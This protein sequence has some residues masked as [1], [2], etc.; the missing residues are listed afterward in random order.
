M[1]LLGR[2]AALI[3]G[4]LLVGLCE[5]GLWL[6]DIGPNDDLFIAEGDSYR[7]NPQAARRFFPHQYARLAPGQDRF[8]R[9][10]GA[11]TFRVFALGAS[12]LLGFPNPPQTSFP[13]FLQLMLE[14][15][16]PG[17]RIEVVNCG[18]T[19]INSFVLLDFIEEVVE[20][21][22][23]LVLIY[24]GHNEFV[25]P[26]GAATPFVRLGSSGSFIR[27]QMV[28]QRSKIYYLL[29]EVV[30]HAGEL[31]QGE[32]KNSSFG[33]HLVQREVYP[34]DEAHRLTE[35]NYRRNLLEILEVVR[36]NEV[37][38]ALCTLASNLEG[39][40]P[41]RSQGAAPPVDGTAPQ[42]QLQTY[43]HHAAVHFEAGLAYRAAGDSVRALAT[44]TQA[45]DHDGIHLRAC[46]PFNEII[47]SLAP[48]VWLV[49][50]ERDFATHASHGL[51]GDE[52]ITEY[53]H[54]TVWGHYLIARSAFKEIAARAGALGLAGGDPD[55]LDTFAD[56]SRRLGYG[57]RERILARNDLMLLLLNMPYA[58]RPETLERRLAQ[59]VELQLRE[60]PR[61]SYAQIADFAQRGG[62][63][64]LAKVIAE[65]K[66]AQS[67][68]EALEGLAGPLG[69][70]P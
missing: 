16:Y 26:Y 5:A 27:W 66:D 56:Y 31:L 67:L 51:I 21:Q 37:P 68:A 42:D 59:L 1:Q 6:V 32:G 11:D 25:G 38:L 61:L 8:D 29:G 20:Q 22:P 50:I 12:T 52:L 70:A 9:E 41:L 14:D 33:L 44:F 64:F 7:L 2:F 4:L 28:L 60:L 23:D 49:D 3:A 62:V 19:A 15:A 40:Y 35:A 65:L 36:D 13:N 24:A 58:A 45:R 63:V 55:G 48:G 69:L 39:F 30:H 18:I 53:L 10:K 17:R 47:R 34:G 43:P 57:V 46:T 54:P